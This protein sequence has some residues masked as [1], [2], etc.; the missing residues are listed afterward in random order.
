MVVGPSSPPWLDMVNVR[1]WDTAFPAPR[2][3]LQVFIAYLA[4]LGTVT[5]LGR[6]TAPVL[7]AAA[8]PDR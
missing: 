2:L 1:R 8:L 4:P 7:L 6:C 3:H 5:P